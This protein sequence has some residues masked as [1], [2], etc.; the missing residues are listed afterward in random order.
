VRERTGPRKLEIVE[1]FSTV[2]RRLVVAAC[3]TYLGAGME[4]SR[5]RTSSLTLAV[6]V[7]AAGAAVGALGAVAL[8]TSI[9][10]GTAVGLIVATTA[11]SLVSATIL[12]IAG[13]VRA[14]GRSPTDVLDERHRRPAPPTR[15]PA[16]YP[17]EPR[18]GEHVLPSAVAVFFLLLSLLLGIGAVWGGG[19]AAYGWASASSLITAALTGLWWISARQAPPPP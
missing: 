16:V 18:R 15:R 12:A 2:G 11:V 10:F 9:P 5:F 1:T 8:G 17:L 4:A 3:R 14:T 19:A 7:T 13:A 6:V